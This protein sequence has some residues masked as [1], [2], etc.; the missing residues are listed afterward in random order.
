MQKKLG[1]FC[2]ASNTIDS[3]YN[4]VAREMVRAASLRGYTIVSGGT[5][6]GT[7]G[8][9]A[10]ELQTIGGSHLGI[11]PRFMEPLVH[12]GLTETV[13]TETMA[14]RKGLMREGTVAVVALPGGIGTLDEF[15]ET[16]TLRKLDQYQGGVYALNCYGF[17]DPL[18]KLLDYYVETEMLDARSRRLA[19]FPKTVDELMTLLEKEKDES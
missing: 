12:K 4:E 2:S 14:E 3:K 18:E 15:I 5:V 17:Y 9:I 16:L 11:I 13:W 6:K 7:M 19:L 10:D 8:V 1:V